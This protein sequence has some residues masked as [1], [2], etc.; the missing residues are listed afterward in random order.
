MLERYNLADALNKSPIENPVER[1]MDL[2]IG[3]LLRYGVL[4]AGVVILVGG[5]LYLFKFGGD[6]PQ[7][8][9]FHGQLA[10]LTTIGGIFQAAASFRPRGIIQLGF[11]LLI[12]TPV[13]RV[14]FSV[15]AF[16]RQRDQIYI[17]VT[18]FVLALLIF[19]LS[20]VHL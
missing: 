10:D 8:R 5:I 15:F 19:S 16:I 1:Q 4:I 17:A 7:Y 20:G 11:L 12:A 18:L 14:A 13:A 2:M 6:L 3:T 9:K